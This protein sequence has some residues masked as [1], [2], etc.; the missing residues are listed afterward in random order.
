MNR[1]RLLTTAFFVLIMGAIGYWIYLT[2]L[3]P[4]P[5]VAAGVPEQ[6]NANSG[7]DLVS[8][9]G[10]VVP[11]RRAQLSFVSGGSVADVLVVVGE[12]V[13]SGQPLVRLDATDLEGAVAEA[14]AAVAQAEAGVLAAQA[15][16]A[17]AEAACQSA[18]LSVLA[19]QSQ[20]A[21]AQAAPRQEELDV[22]EAN[23]AAADAAIGLAA[24]QRDIAVSGP[25]AAQIQA[26]E[27]QLAAAQAEEDI[28]RVQYN[29]MIAQ[30]MLGTQEEQMRRKVWAAEEAT[31]AAQAALDEMAAGA[32]QAQRSAASSEVGI[33]VAQRDA[34][35]AQLD[36]LV[37]GPRV[38]ELAVLEIGVRAAEAAVAQAETAV[39]QAAA[40]LAQ[41]EAAVSQAEAARDAAHAALAKMTLTAPF[42]GVVADVTAEAGEIVAPGVPVVRVAAGQGWA[43]ETTDLTELDVVAVAVG[44]AVEVR[45]DA[46]PDKVVAG[47][48]TEVAAFAT[49][50]RG[51]TTYAVTIRLED[52]DALPLRWGMTAF[53]DIDVSS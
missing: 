23:I 12:S 37:A 19:A 49:Q 16:V 27:A 20:L 50:A 47:T 53:V 33:T 51:N 38:E 48:V 11:L 2:Y 36:L 25:T 44:D 46:V 28:L 45:I 42:A 41:A 7:S 6:G 39:D 52:A 43:V 4:V 10:Q 13:T 8:A 24:A 30:G 3:A 34:A 22:L 40:A 15:Q 5:E 1:K 21:L 26:A 32:D 18:E 17:A 35:Q 9:E 31:A 29:L 14:E